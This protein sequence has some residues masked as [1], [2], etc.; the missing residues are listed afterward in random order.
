L[1]GFVLCLA[2]GIASDQ[3]DVHA[4]IPFNGDAG[5]VVRLLSDVPRLREILPED[6]A[7]KWVGSG[8]GVGSS[9]EVTY[10]MGW[11]KR[12]L[13][14]TITRAD[15]RQGVEWDHHGNRGFVT[16]WTVTG[17]ENGSVLGVTTW[18]HPPPWPFKRTYYKRIKPRWEL[19]Y[20]QALDYVV[21]QVS[22][23]DD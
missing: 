18:I 22:G 19:C 3:S 15:A 11:W 14:A 13:E 16:R 5:E 17:N 6:C 8:T 2:L 10:T 12:R 20:R 23:V 21:D 1:I 9:F 4:E 7:R